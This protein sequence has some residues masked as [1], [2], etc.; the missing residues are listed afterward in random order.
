MLSDNYVRK[1]YSSKEVVIRIA[2]FLFNC[3]HYAVVEQP[4]VAD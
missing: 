4:Q 2:D 3:P 1:K